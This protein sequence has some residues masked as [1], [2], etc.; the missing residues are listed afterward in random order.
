MFTKF[1]INQVYQIIIVY[2]ICLRFEISYLIFWHGVIFKFQANIALSL[3]DHSN[4]L[5]SSYSKFLVYFYYAD[6][7]FHLENYRKAE[8]LYRKALQFRK[9]LLKCKGT[10]KP[11]TE[12]QKELVSDVDIKYQI[13]SCWVKMKNTSEAL[14]ILQGIPG[15]QRTPKVNEK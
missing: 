5:L 6:S 10:A 7:H 15:K 12:S 3:S 4:E 2:I 11:T 8:A 14:H 13:Y 9:C 1:I